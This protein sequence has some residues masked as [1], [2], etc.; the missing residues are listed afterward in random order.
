MKLFSP[1]KLHFITIEMGNNRNRRRSK[2]EQLPSL[3]RETS[4]SEAEASKGIETIIE[5]LSE[6]DNV[7][8]VRGREPVLIDSTQNENEIQGVDSQ[9]N[10]KYEQKI[11]RAKERDE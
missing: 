4:A 6:F 10:R 7:C 8:A 3:G 5:T 11:G 9:G 1:T 2:R